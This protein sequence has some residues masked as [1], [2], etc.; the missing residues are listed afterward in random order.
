[1]STS[2]FQRNSHCKLVSA[3]ISLSTSVH[4]YTPP[5]KVRSPGHARFRDSTLT[6]TTQTLR[7]PISLHHHPLSSVPDLPR[8][9]TPGRSFL[10]PKI[11]LT[12]SYPMEI[13]VPLTGLHPKLSWGDRR[14]PFSPVSLNPLDTPSRP[15]GRWQVRSLPSPRL[16]PQGTFSSPPV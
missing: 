5:P 4:L 6:K 16:V 14:P 13:L 12:S 3:L 9:S 15:R 2:L 11:T 1:M 10:N 7:H 8:S